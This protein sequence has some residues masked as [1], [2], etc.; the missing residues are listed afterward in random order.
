MNYLIANIWPLMGAFWAGII[1]GCIV[2]VLGFKRGIEDA[3]KQAVGRGLG[4]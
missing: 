4:W 3:M 1:V 2:G